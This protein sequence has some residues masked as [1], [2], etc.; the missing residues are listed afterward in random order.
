MKN[1]EI[2]YLAGLFDGEGSCSIQLMKKNYGINYNARMTMS[3][4]YGHDVLNKL[5]KI[6]GGKIYYYKD[7]MARW[8]LGQKLMMIRA[9]DLMIPYLNI[10]KDIANKFKYALSLMPEHRTKYI[11]NKQR[12]ELNTIALTLNPTKSR[13]RR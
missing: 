11:N 4:K 9:L 13:K 8:H 5:V 3:L 2:A 12:E 7:N 10:K 1:T 6:F